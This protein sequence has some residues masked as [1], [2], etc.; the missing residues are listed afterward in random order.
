MSKRMIALV[1][2]VGLCLACVVAVGVASTTS[3]R[4][5]EAPSGGQ[6]AVEKAEGQDAGSSSSSDAGQAPV[7]EGARGEAEGDGGAKAAGEYT[8]AAAE[9]VEVLTSA[10][11]VD[12]SSGASLVFR[13]DG[14]YGVAART[15]DA[16]SD[17]FR[18]LAVKGDPDGAGGATVIVQLGSDYDVMSFVRNTQDNAAS[19]EGYPESPY[20]VYCDALGTSFYRDASQTVAVQRVDAGPAEVVDN[21][22][23]IAAAVTAYC[24]AELPTVTEARWVGTATY[25]WRDPAAPSVTAGYQCDDAKATKVFVVVNAST[26]E[27]FVPDEHGSYV[28]GSVNANGEPVGSSGEGA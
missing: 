5:G 15:G 24:L 13:E 6:A 17:P 4:G 14:T 2:V 21:Q 25:N 27:C 8:G 26:G 3:Q 7:P 20:K 23:A 9:V 18:V 11:F 16:G 22:D 28:D 10:T 19:F 1:A 12:P